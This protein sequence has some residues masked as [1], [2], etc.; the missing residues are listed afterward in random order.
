MFCVAVSNALTRCLSLDEADWQIASMDELSLPELMQRHAAIFGPQT[1]ERVVIGAHYDS[2]GPLPGADDNASG[3]AGLIE[4]AHLLG[5]A[6]KASLNTSVELVAYTLEEPPFFAT[7][8]MGSAVHAASLKQQRVP[9]RLMLSLEMIGYFTDAP[10]SQRYPVAAMKLTYPSVG[11]FIA[12][13]G[14]IGQGATVQRIKEAMQSASSLPVQFLNA[15][16]SLPGV[17]LSDHRNYWNA[18]YEAA[19]ITD[20]SF[21]RNPSYHTAQDTPDTLDYQR[22]A[23]VVEGIYAVALAEAR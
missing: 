7:Q 8:H 9:V 2:A 1:K 16:S 13:V 6:P 17:D 4:L 11:N 18:G 10:N 20:T 19:M 12:V 14:K 21:Y 15:P 22:M 3:V 23:L 5:R